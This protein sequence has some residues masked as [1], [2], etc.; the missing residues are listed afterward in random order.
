MIKIEISSMEDLNEIGNNITLL[1]LLREINEFEI[2]IFIFLFKDN[3][4]C[5]CFSTTNNNNNNFYNNQQIFN[6]N[7][8]N[9]NTNSFINK[10]YFMNSYKRKI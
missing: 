8:N 4:F 2:D 1:Q 7:D 10:K 9:D 5:C 3:H 6:N